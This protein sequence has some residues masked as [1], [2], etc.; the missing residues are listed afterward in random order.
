MFKI[1]KRIIRKRP[2]SMARVIS[3][4]LRCSRRN[5]YVGDRHSDLISDKD[6]GTFIAQANIDRWTYKNEMWD[7]DD[8]SLQF[9]AAAKRYFAPKGINAAIGIIWTYKHAFNLS[10]NPDRKV[11]LWEPQTG[12]RCF[13]HGRVRLVVI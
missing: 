10:V 2:K 1:K 12:K 13:L 8:F 9:A 4:E 5:I 11:R 7:C 3:S 6:M